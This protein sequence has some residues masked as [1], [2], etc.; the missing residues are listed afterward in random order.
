MYIPCTIYSSNTDT[1]S[2]IIQSFLNASIYIQEC[3]KTQHNTSLHNLTER[4]VITLHFTDP[5]KLF[6]GVRGAPATLSTR[7]PRKKIPDVME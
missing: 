3:K 5:S 1:V 2:K 6:R 7:L 4:F